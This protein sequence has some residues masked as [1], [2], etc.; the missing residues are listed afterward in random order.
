MKLGDV[1]VYHLDT[2]NFTQLNKERNTQPDKQS[3]AQQQQTKEHMILKC[4][5]K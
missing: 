2:G 3:K 4:T 1:L 5:H